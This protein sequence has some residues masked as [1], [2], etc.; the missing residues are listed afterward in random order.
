MRKKFIG[1]WN[2]KSDCTI[3]YASKECTYLENIL[4]S[5]DPDIIHNVI[6]IKFGWYV[7]GSIEIFNQIIST[8]RELS[9][10]IIIDIP[11]SLSS[12]ISSI[13]LNHKLSNIQLSIL[14]HLLQGGRYHYVDDAWS[15]L[16]FKTRV[17]PCC[18]PLDIDNFLVCNSQQKIYLQ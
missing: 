16:F 7:N 10:I 9:E 4:P 11:D 6:M 2:W 3:P 18:S 12:Q 17:F 14:K 8:L 15:C 13:K 5:H 1:T